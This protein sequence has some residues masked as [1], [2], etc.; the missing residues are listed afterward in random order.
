MEFC[1]MR[2]E[3]FWKNGETELFVEGVNSRAQEEGGWF[4]GFLVK[5]SK[6]IVWWDTIW[7]QWKGENREFVRNARARD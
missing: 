3:F 4:F 1:D 6:V 2:G 5:G 7:I